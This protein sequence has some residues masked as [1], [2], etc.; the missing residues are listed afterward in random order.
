MLPVIPNLICLATAD[1]SATKD[2]RITAKVLAASVMRNLPVAEVKALRSAVAMAG[3]GL[4]S[5]WRKLG[6][7]RNLKEDG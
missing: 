5:K 2:S 6:W 3:G 1:I 4:Y 7:R